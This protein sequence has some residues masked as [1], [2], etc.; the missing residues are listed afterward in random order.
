MNLEEIVLSCSTPQLSHSL[1]KRCALNVS[2]SA[3]QF[4]Y[5]DIGCLLRV[6]NRNFRNSLDPVLDGIC[7]MRHDLHCFSKIIAPSLSLD[8][9]LIH[10]PRSNIVFASQSNVEIAFVIAE[11]EVD[12]TTVIENEYFAMPARKTMVKL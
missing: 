8:N 7:D 12:F 4:D 6:V 1:D 10:L 3:T 5:T 2:N 9:M 11:I